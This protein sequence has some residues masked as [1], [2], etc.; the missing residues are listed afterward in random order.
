M[1]V[2]Y[3]DSGLEKLIRSLQESTIAKVV[4]MVEL[5]EEFGSTLGMPQSKSVARHLFELRIRGQQEVRIFYTFHNG[6]AV[7]LHGFIKKSERIPGR[8]LNT[9]KQKLAALDRA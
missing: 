6:R 2:Q 3:F 7:L 5:L 1:E 8:E 9:A 4:R